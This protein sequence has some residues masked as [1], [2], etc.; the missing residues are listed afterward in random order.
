M[1]VRTLHDL[2]IK[3]IRDLY[4]ADTQLVAGLPG[5]AA[6]ATNR[7]LRDSITDHVKQTNG[8]MDRL[9]MIFEALKADPLGHECL[10]MEGL[11][12]EAADFAQDVR[13]GPLR[14]AALIVACQKI[15][16]YEICG[17]GCSKTFANLLGY[18]EHI[19]LLEANENDGVEAD[20]FFNQIALE[21]INPLALLSAA[22]SAEP[23]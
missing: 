13:A 23:L 5:L 12:K 10:A 8:Q 21:R 4:S 19:D 2:Y 17:Y 9:E 1:K 15:E 20:Q 18:S 7:E 16:Q 11:L 3:E 14:D 6:A 22:S